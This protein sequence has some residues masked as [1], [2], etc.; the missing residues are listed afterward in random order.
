[1]GF[2][3]ILKSVFSSSQDE[4]IDK[5]N[6]EAIN[7]LSQGLK[8]LQTKNK[9]IRGNRIGQLMEGFKT[10]QALVD[11]TTVEKKHLS[12]LEKDYNRAI[13]AYANEYKEF[14]KLYNTANGN[15]IKC[16]KNCMKKHTST[17][18]QG[19]RLRESC[20]AG[21]NIKGPFVSQC[22]DSYTGWQQDTSKK[23]SKMTT[24]K[25]NKG[26]IEM[27]Q[28]SYV[29]NA[30]YGDNKSRTLASGCCDCGGG[31]GGPPKHK[32]KGKNVSNCEEIHTAFGLQK[33]QTDS[34]PLIDACKTAVYEDQNKSATL[35]LEYNKLKAKNDSLMAQANRIWNKI[36]KLKGIRKG[37]NNIL[38]KEE[39]GMKVKYDDF[40]DTYTKIV[41]LD[42]SGKSENTTLNAQADDAILK[43]QSESLKYYAWIILALLVTSGALWKMNEKKK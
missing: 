38:R 2:S 22:T 30:S 31:S 27:G 36:T 23:C 14:M 35:Y 7:D 28:A 24:G 34:Q 29:N 15:R 20:L 43:E 6:E 8:H 12:D 40:S 32:I 10:P 42:Q 18:A 17:S 3:E 41:G 1:M 11:A 16:L 13:T 33:G 37:I 5:F 4:K 26:K 25:C 39:R 19:T 9:Q 21:C